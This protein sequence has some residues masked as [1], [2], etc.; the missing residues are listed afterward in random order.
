MVP[1]SEVLLEAA[2]PLVG[3]AHDYDPL[4]DLIGDARV[5]LLGEASHAVASLFGT[6][7]KRAMDEN[8]VRLKSLLEEGKTTADEGQVRLDEVT[9]AR[10]QN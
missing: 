8:M 5:V 7:P 3:G 1:P 6:D 10:P 4:M 9:E 2:H